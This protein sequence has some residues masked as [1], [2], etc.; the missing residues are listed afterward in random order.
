M[1]ALATYCALS[2]YR[3]TP[4]ITPLERSHG[5]DTEP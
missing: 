3:M 1:S 4:T 5:F 2:M